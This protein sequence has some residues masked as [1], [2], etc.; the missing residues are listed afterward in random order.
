MRLLDWCRGRILWIL[1]KLKRPLRLRSIFEESYFGIRDGHI[2]YNSNYK[3]PLKIVAETAYGGNEVIRG[4]SGFLFLA[5]FILLITFIDFKY[6][7]LFFTL[8]YNMSVEDLRP[9]EHYITMQR[10]SWII[11]PI[12]A[13]IF[14]IVAI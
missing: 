5:I 12:I 1:I 2:N 13:V 4:E 3:L 14:L 7:L 9:S 8:K 6:P 10:L 11:L